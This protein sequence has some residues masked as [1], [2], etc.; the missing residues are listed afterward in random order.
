MKLIVKRHII[1]QQRTVLGHYSG[2]EVEM[3]AKD[4]MVAWPQKSTCHADR[5][6]VDAHL[7][8]FGHLCHLSLLGCPVHGS[9]GPTLWGGERSIMDLSGP[10]PLDEVAPSGP[11]WHW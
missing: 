10:R 4:D 1:A 11:L 5:S 8:V 3:D 7:H 2:G 9:H 6:N